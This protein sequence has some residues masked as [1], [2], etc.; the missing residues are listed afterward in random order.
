MVKTAG[1]RIL[2]AAGLLILAQQVGAQ[3]AAAGSPQ[4]VSGKI[5]PGAAGG[6]AG[7]P[8]GVALV[9]SQAGTQAVKQT[10]LALQ[11]QKLVAMATELKA[12]V[13]R[14]NKDILSC[15]VVRQAQDIEQYAHQMK[16]NDVKK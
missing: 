16:Q 5:V 3:S 12:S 1:W 2:V 6:V 11:A 14:T 8:G 15:A 4:G 10:A 13:D 9:A 7:A